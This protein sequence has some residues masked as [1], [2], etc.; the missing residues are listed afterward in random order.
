M[1]SYW[2]IKFAALLHDIGKF[3]QRAKT[4]LKHEKL[5]QIFAESNLPDEIASILPGLI[6]QQDFNVIQYNKESR[7]VHIADM[8]ASGEREKIEKKE[9]EVDKIPLKSIFSRIILDEY[10]EPKQMAYFPTPLIGKEEM[11]PIPKE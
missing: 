9:I 2:K 5:S 7:I 1:D 10:N 8:L 4:K 11:F 3:Q 6:Y